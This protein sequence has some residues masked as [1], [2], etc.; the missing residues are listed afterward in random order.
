M[1]LAASLFSACGSDD[2]AEDGSPALTVVASDLVFPARASTHDIEVSCQG[3]F[4]ASVNKEWCTVTTD[5]NRVH[6]A[7]ER[8]T[9]LESRNAIVTLEGGG[10]NLRLSLMQ[11]GAVW[12]VRGLSSYSASDE[13]TTILI[14]ATLDFDYTVTK[15]DWMDGEEVEDGYLLHLHANDTGGARKGNVIIKSSQGSKTISFQQFGKRS[16]GGQYD[17]TY[18]YINSVTD[19]LGRVVENTVTVT[20]RIRIEAENTQS[21]LYLVGLHDK[22][23]IPVSMSSDG[24]LHIANGHLMDGATSGY[25]YIVLH[26]EGPYQNFIF[27]GD[28]DYQAPLKLTNKGGVYIPSFAFPKKSVTF[29]DPTGSEATIVADG[30]SVKTATLPDIRFTQAGDELGQYMNIS[31]TKV[32]E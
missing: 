16:V 30:F 15:P 11:S 14:P 10:T 22:Y 29:I 3:V 5:G 8:N 19:R 6:V 21:Y 23:P 32:L 7:V 18:S 31:L 12:M 24:T 17:I 1:A 25:L 4:T 27:A 2:G 20:K 28:C 9:E 26:Q 13:D